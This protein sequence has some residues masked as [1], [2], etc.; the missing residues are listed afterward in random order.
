MMENDFT[1]SVEDVF[2]SAAVFGDGTK[3]RLICV[4]LAA[5]RPDDLAIH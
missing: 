1:E 5:D 2:E 3:P 4:A